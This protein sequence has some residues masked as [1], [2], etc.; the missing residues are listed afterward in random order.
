V[1]YPA[2]FKQDY[3]IQEEE[4]RDLVPGF[5]A[6]FWKLQQYALNSNDRDALSRIALETQRNLESEALTVLADKGHMCSLKM[7]FYDRLLLTN[8]TLANTTAKQHARGW[9]DSDAKPTTNLN[10]PR[11]NRAALL[12]GHDPCY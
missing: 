5:V 8:K 9:G 3:Y 11:T 6:A 1:F 10:R 7:P 4:A 2:I 12:K